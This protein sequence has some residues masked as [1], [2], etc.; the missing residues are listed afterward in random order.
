MR[1]CAKEALEAEE[2]KEAATSEAKSQQNANTFVSKEQKNLLLLDM[3]H[4][5][6]A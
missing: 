4:V 3:F 5:A 6:N 1:D 2:K